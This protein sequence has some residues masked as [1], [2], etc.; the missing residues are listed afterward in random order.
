[1]AKSKR[2]YFER[3]GRKPPSYMVDR[4][5][6]LAAANKKCKGTINKDGQFYKCVAEELKK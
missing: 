4:G 6:K 3:T 2:S 5:K 1:M